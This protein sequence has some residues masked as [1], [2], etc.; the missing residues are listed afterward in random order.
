M[1]TIVEHRFGSVWTEEKLDV[2]MNY[3]DIYSTALRNTKWGLVYI[4]AFAGTGSREYDDETGNT[5]SCPGSVLRSLQI[6]NPFSQYYFIEKDV[7]KAAE[8]RR[9]LGEMRVNKGLVWNGDANNELPKIIQKL[10]GPLHRGVVFLD[11]FAM[12]V[13][14]RTLKAIAASRILDLWFL[15]PFGAISRTLPREGEVNESWRQK[16]ISTF[17]EDP[18]PHLYKVTRQ[19]SLFGDTEDLDM[20]N[21]NEDCP[22]RVGGPGMLARYIL[23]R[24]RSIFAW[25]SSDV[26]VLRNSNNAPMFHLVYALSNPSDKAISLAQKLIKSILKKHKEG[27]GY[28]QSVGN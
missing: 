9:K 26:V 21:I 27:G 5:L 23:N 28:V 18:I 19:P 16:L 25:V 14:W 1:D 20:F 11:P 17:G 13:E 7:E 15:V 3:L 24:L 12:T 2:V 22:V 8:L 4:D 6:S 10:E